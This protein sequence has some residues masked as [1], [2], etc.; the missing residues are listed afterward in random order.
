MGTSDWYDIPFNR[1]SGFEKAEI[2]YWKLLFWSLFRRPHL[3]HIAIA[4]S[5]YGFVIQKEVFSLA[6]RRFKMVRNGYP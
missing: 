2:R 4:C 6:G 3:L 1:G 5:I